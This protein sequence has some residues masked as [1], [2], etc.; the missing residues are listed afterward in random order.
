MRQLSIESPLSVDDCAL[1]D[2][3]RDQPK[4]AELLRPQDDVVPGVSRRQFVRQRVQAML[5]LCAAGGVDVFGSDLAVRRVPRPRQCSRSMEG[6]FDLPAGEAEAAGEGAE[7]AIVERERGVERR[8]PPLAPLTVGRLRHLETEK[9]PSVE[10]ARRLPCPLADEDRRWPAL[11]QCL[12]ESV[13]LVL[14]IGTRAQ[15]AIHLIEAE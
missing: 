15:E 1:P 7:V 13:V 10:A 4:R 6:V 9:G 11:R 3:R 5:R 8:G 12:H 14:T 2:H